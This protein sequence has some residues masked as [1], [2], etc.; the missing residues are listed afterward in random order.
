M[1]T[2]TDRASHLATKAARSVPTAEQSAKGLGWFS[3]ALGLT[4]LLAARKLTGALDVRGKEPIVRAMGLREIASGAL[5]ARDKRKGAWSRVAGDAL[6]VAALAAVF[7]G[8]R[9]KR[10]VAIA[11]GAVAGAGLLDLVTARALGKRPTVKRS[12]AKQ[13]AVTA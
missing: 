6:D 2:L 8:N 4:E 7:P 13:A 5:I 12:G 1:P 3:L 9:R 10:N 11:L